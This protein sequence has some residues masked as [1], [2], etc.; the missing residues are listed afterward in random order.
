MPS[1]LGVILLLFWGCGKPPEPTVGFAEDIAPIL[2]ENCTI[3]HH[4]DGI[5]PFNLVSYEDVSKRA[6][7]VADVVADRYMPPW[8]PAFD[9]GPVLKDTRRLSEE[10]IA[11]IQAWERAGAPSGD[12]SQLPPAPVYEDGWTLGE[13][14][15]VVEMS[16]PFQLQAEGGDVFRN[17]VIPIPLDSPRYIRAIEFLPETKLAIH[18]AIIAVDPT[19]ASRRLD[20]RDPG[21]GFDSMDLGAAVRPFGH[22]IGW[23]PGQVPYEAYPGTA[24]RVE[25]GTDL[26]VQLHMLPSGKTENVSPKIGL[27][28]SEEPPT[29]YSMIV[30]LWEYDIDISAGDSNYE[31]EESFV[32]PVATQVL[33][34]FPHAH[35]LGK[36]MRIWAEVPG[37]EKQWLLHIPDWDFNWQSDYRFLEPLSLPANT[38]VVMRYSYDNSESNFRNPHS[39]PIRVK[40]GFDSFDEMGDVAIQVLLNEPSD[41]AILQEA[42]SRYDISVM[43]KLPAH[44]SSLARAL[45]QQGRVDEAIQIL[46]ELVGLYPGDESSVL[47]LSRLHSSQENWEAAV[48]VLLNGLSEHGMSPQYRIQ[49]GKTYLEFG[50]PSRASSHFEEA[51]RLLETVN[52]GLA[53]DCMY[54]V[55][56][57]KMSQ[58][59]W[60]AVRSSLEKIL[61]MSP[62]HI[63]AHLMSAAVEIAGNNLEGAQRHLL[64]VIE[65]SEPKRPTD[66]MI[67]GLLPFPNGGVV[68]ARTYLQVGNASKA[69]E[70]IRETVR[71]AR[72][73]GLSAA[74]EYLENLETQISEELE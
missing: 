70:V 64:V 8:K 53:A 39:P 45:D 58:G 56:T 57:I 47:D 60:G 63:E 4:S 40:R 15:V 65:S 19:D 69:L 46:E 11:L 13:P 20:A 54:E 10:E 59:D 62:E 43:G 22:L 14:D 42:Q 16:E 66:D 33:G 28:F 32:I 51:A 7:L 27:F 25:P 6:R 35:Y 61:A 29:R 37:G 67:L 71:G 23:T 3:C 49:L 1:F 18:H 48:R 26:V 21:P 50:I 55:A 72:I 12:L 38:R 24:W 2:Y 44:L 36:D 52:P 74:L 9:H 5:G 34:L 73:N 31:V 68:L 41:W 17:L 30:Q